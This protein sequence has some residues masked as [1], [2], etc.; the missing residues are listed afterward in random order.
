LK[1]A[2]HLRLALLTLGHESREFFVHSVVAAEK[3]VHFV[4]FDGEACLDRLFASPV[5]AVRLTLNENLSVVDIPVPAEANC[6]CTFRLLEAAQIEIKI[7]VVKI[8][9][10]NSRVFEFKLLVRIKDCDID[11]LDGQSFKDE[12]DSTPRTGRCRIMASL[13]GTRLSGWT[14]YFVVCRTNAL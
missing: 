6:L 11:E 12:I 2:V 4:F 3:G 9:R 10:C 7:F 13:S 8:N 5:L 1:H 14:Q